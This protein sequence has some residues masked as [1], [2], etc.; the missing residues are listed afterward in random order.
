MKLW[1]Y[2]G[3]CSFF[4]CETQRPLHCLLQIADFWD[5][6]EWTR[7]RHKGCSDCQRMN[8]SNLNFA[9]LYHLTFD[10]QIQ[11]LNHFIYQKKC[12]SSICFSSSFYRK[13]Q[14]TCNVFTFEIISN[15]QSSKIHVESVSWYLDCLERV[16]QLELSCY[17]L[18]V[19]LVCLKESE[20]CLSWV[21]LNSIF[22]HWKL[23]IPC[24][25]GHWFSTC[26]MDYSELM[27]VCPIRLRKRFF[28]L[29]D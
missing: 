2:L 29:W 27:Q 15:T 28:W 5:L 11:S 20:N 24:Y 18:N 21:L 6:L 10:L 26:W 9:H 8:L 12:V 22:P 4:L 19:A 25:C 13:F 23:K 16:R 14:F 3:E 17:L 1:A 7:L